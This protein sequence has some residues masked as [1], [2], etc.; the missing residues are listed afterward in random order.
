MPNEI[1]AV[2]SYFNP[3]GYETRLTNYHLFREALDAP[4]VTVELS[5]GRGPDLKPSD[6]DWLIQISTDQVLWQ[7][8]RLLNI[9][10]TALPD[11]CRYVVWLDCDVVFRRS[12][13]ISETAKALETF[14][15][16]Q[17]YS[18]VLDTERGADP[19]QLSTAPVLHKRTSMGA[20]YMKGGFE[21]T[22]TRT[23]SLEQHSPGHAWATRREVL[24]KGFYDA[25]ILGSGDH[26]IAMASIGRWEEVVDAYE[27]N[28]RLAQHYRQWAAQW[29]ERV[30]GRLGFVDGELYHLWHGS[31]HDRGYEERYPSIRSFNFDPEADIAVAENGSWKWSSPKPDLHRVVSQY[32]QSRREDGQ[33]SD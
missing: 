31:L 28:D 8:E 11:A 3:V 26:A 23:N 24:E 18:F 25:M 2:T 1:V 4:L 16:V 10:L 7:K 20:L 22:A 17:P 33:P 12:D 14:S 13:W 27:M 6:A 15:V 30:N 29:H 19:A 5:Y 9:A 32:F 21:S